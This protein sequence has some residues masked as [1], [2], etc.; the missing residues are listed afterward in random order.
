[1]VFKSLRKF[2]ERKKARPVEST[3]C[4]IVLGN[5][6][7]VEAFSQFWDQYQEDLAIIGAKELFEIS[8]SEGYSRSEMD[9]FRKG[10]SVYG[11][12][13]EKCY[14]EIQ[15]KRQQAAERE[16]IE[17]SQVSELESEI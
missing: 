1:M 3:E 6:R 7:K 14:L 16:R 13:F 17:S 5:S 2:F 9:F 10:L 12:F 8:S 15:L 4:E 11:K